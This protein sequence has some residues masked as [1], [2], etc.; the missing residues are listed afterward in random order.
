MVARNGGIAQTF[1]QLININQSAPNTFSTVG[2]LSEGVPL[3]PP[4]DLS[5]GT[6]SLPPN[7]G[8]TAID[9]ELTR[10]T[11]TSY[12]LTMQKLLPRALSLTVGYVANRQRDLVRSQNLN[13]GQIG[14]GAASQPF[15]NR[16][17]QRTTHDQQHGR[18]QTARP[19]GPR[20]TASE[21]DAAG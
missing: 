14:G 3:V 8:V 15:N 16:P 20:L 7:T 4:L 10:G 19:H 13:Y 1:P 12:N 11:I 6:V 18:V 9:R 2:S 5:T 17:R 21:S